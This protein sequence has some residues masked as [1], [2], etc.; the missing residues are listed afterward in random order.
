[1]VPTSW[2]FIEG[3]AFTWVRPTTSS[4]LRVVFC[5]CVQLRLPPPR[6]W[7]CFLPLHMHISM[8]V[9]STAPTT[10]RDGWL[11]FPFRWRTQ[12][13]A[14]SGINCRITNYRIFERKR[15]TGETVHRR[16]PWMPQPSVSNKKHSF[17]R[18]FRRCELSRA[19]I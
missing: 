19:R 15:P 3:E 4:R 17:P 16:T 1:V 14:I 11:G 2:P 18:L 9:W 6:R 8:C 7:V 5:V 10:C 13:S 12:Q